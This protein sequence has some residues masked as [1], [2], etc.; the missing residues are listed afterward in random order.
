MNLSLG[1]FETMRLMSTN[2]HPRFATCTKW[3]L[4]ISGWRRRHRPRH[5]G[6]VAAL[7]SSLVPPSQFVPCEKLS[8]GTKGCEGG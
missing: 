4:A 2:M 5:I 6:N 8:S 3:I 1:C 7:G